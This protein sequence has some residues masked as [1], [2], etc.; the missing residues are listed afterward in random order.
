MTELA[1][2]LFTHVEGATAL[3]ARA[4]EQ[5]TD[6]ALAAH[7]AIV[8]EAI[9]RHGG[10]DAVSFEE[11]FTAAFVTARAAV[12]CA[13]AIQRAMD[14]YADEGLRIRAGVHHG[15]VEEGPDGRVGAGVT[16][17]AAIV[18]AARGRQILVS[19]EVRELAGTMP[20][21]QFVDRGEFR[22]S[23]DGEPTRVHEVLWS[24]RRARTT[25]PIPRATTPFVGRES[26]RDELRKVLDAALAGRGS[27]V[28]I[29]GDAGV[30]KSRLA[31][32]LAEEASRRGF[33]ALSGRC[34]DVE[35]PPSFMP[36]LEIL[37]TAMSL[38]PEQV[39]RESMGEAFS[40]IASLLP[41]LGREPDAG[42]GPDRASL[43]D[44][45]RDFLE[46]TSRRRPTLLL[47]EHLQWADP[48]SVA[49]I[50]HSADRLGRLPAVLVGLYR[51]DGI[52]DRPLGE[53]LDGLLS[54][55]VVRRIDL[56]PLAPES[57]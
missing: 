29:S 39:F 16:G 20:G 57:S 13:A 28:L 53:A 25:S 6:E 27:L 19:D 23:A 11:G 49:L 54:L 40:G 1:T 9:E 55:P 35:D 4:G 18:A 44:A 48:E 42:P 37:R 32:D 30:G 26:E 3:R 10:R 52:A 14:A 38:I 5:A 21:L 51:P 31:E 8:G 47:L 17:A 15:P 12:D 36:L 24:I 2:I 50:R 34:E 45:C 43:L 7:E 22:F 56:R 33:L 46:R 41:E